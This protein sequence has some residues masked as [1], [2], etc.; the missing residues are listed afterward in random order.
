MTDR[1]V[2]IVTG[3]ASGIGFAIAKAL[4][5]DGWKLILA[6]L[7]QGP[8][9]AAR[10]ALEPVRANATKCIIMDVADEASVVAGLDGCEA[11]FGP[12][13]GLVNSAGIARDVPFFD[14]SVELFRKVLDINLTGT[15]TVAREAGRLM[16]SHGGGAIVNIASVSGQR[17]NLG[18]SAYGASKGGVITLTQVMACELAPENIRVNAIAPGP[19][20]TPLVQ[21]MQSEADRAAWL[22]EVPQRRYASPDEIAGAASFLMDNTKAGFI[23]GHVLNVDGGFGAAGYLPDRR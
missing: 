15:F 23:T 21:A 18:R 8:L 1:G 4:L 16:R 6:D 13:K 3:G 5:A 7:A 17:G 10:A 12:V 20:E 14:T 11:G 19:V 9:D 22:R 2:A